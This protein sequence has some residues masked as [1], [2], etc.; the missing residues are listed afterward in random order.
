MALPVEAIDVRVKAGEREIV[1]G[2]SLALQQG[3]LT[4]LVGPN[5]AGK[6]TMLRAIAGLVPIADGDVRLNGSSV[7]TW[8]SVKRARSMAYLAQDRIVGW[9]LTV[10]QIVSLGRLPH[11][12]RSLTADAAAVQDAMARTETLNL[13]NRPISTISG[14]ERGRVL[15]ARSLAVEAEVLLADEPTA[16]LDPRHQLATMRLLQNEARRGTALLVVV[17]DLSLAAR[18]CDHV[19]VMHEGRIAIAGP[20]DEALSLASIT[21]SFGVLAVEGQHRGQRY[22]LPWE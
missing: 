19:A 17:H 16:G 2:V 5:G 4:G 12:D 20:P 14:G 10:R 22:V 1:A 21:T 15:L 11:G 6:S 7:S 9:D 13:A 8:S 3:M 18:F